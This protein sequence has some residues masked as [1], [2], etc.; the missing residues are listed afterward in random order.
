L[1]AFWLFATSYGA[2]AANNRPGTTTISF[3][4][5]ADDTVRTLRSIGQAELVY[6]SFLHVLRANIGNIVSAY[7]QDLCRVSELQLLQLNMH[8]AVLD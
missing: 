4:A 8:A 2:I 6:E 7:E 3:A 1:R 5:I